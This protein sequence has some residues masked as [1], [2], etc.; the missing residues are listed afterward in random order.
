MEDHDDFEFNYCP[1]C[2][3][4]CL[5]W[6]GRDAVFC[7]GQMRKCRNCNRLWHVIRKYEEAAS[8][9]PE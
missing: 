1:H 4:R 2:G 8:D 5:K 3:S 9:E 6:P 7:S